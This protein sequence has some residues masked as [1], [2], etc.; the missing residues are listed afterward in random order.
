MGEKI[1][2]HVGD[3]VYIV[4][5]GFDGMNEK[6]FGILGHNGKRYYLRT[7]RDMLEFNVRDVVDLYPYMRLRNWDE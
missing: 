2:Q 1:N 3:P 6:L 4:L 7:D 5:K